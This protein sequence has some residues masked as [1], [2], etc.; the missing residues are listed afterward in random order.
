MTIP[1]ASAAEAHGYNLSPLRGC[2]KIESRLRFFSKRA[3]LFFM[4]KTHRE[5]R[6]ESRIKTA[7]RHQVEMHCLSLDQMIRD[8]HLVRTVVEYVDSLDLSE[9]YDQIKSTQG[10]SGRAAIDPRIL[11]SLWLFAT[12]EGENSGRRVARLTERDL[13]YMWICG[14]VSVNYHTLCDFRTE[15]GELL[16][17][18]LTDSVA[19]LHYH[20]LV[21]LTTL[22]QDGMRVRAH[23]G[24]G[25]FR[26]QESLEESL[27]QAEA[28]LEK[29][30]QSSPEEGESDD[31]NKDEDN[32]SKG[33]QSAR[34]RA[35]RERVNRVRAACQEVEVLQEKW[36]KRN[37]GKSEKH[38]ASPP[39]VSTTD[40]EARRMKMPNNGFSPAMNVQ[41]ASDADKLIIASVDVCNDGNDGT[42]L[43][44]LY[45][46]VCRDYGVVP[47]R[48]LADGGF[49]TKSSVIHVENHGT[50][51]YGPLH[52]EKKQL[53][54]G[55]DPYA[56]RPEESEIYSNFRQ[57]MGT[58]EAKKIY[59]KRAAAAEFPNAVC[60]NQD[61]EQFSVRGLV[62]T[63]AQTFWHALAYNFRRFLNLK[64]EATEKTYLEIVMTS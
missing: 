3:S 35:A 17:R 43:P 37:K 55:K 58:P 51:F 42:L 36:A 32:P 31:P 46:K 6:G 48:Y 23:A 63:R 8:D 41:F 7:E 13:A 62:K 50:K 44:P 34:Q 59:K 25:S 21:E 30:D 47:E 26:K 1:W 24:S 40:P 60:R 11:F 18:I 29:L 12:L 9:L 5:Q 28:Y 45:D 14:G 16:D 52:R 33:Q 2:E 53:E 49:S 19:I 27:R 4:S 39:R 22:A 57:R 54:E 56:P 10:N 15:N 61:L 64:D 38:K 20:G